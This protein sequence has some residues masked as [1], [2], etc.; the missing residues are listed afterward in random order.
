MS[1]LGPLFEGDFN[2]GPSTDVSQFG[3]GDLSVHRNVIINGTINS[4][5]SNSIGSLLLSG[6]ALI[7][8]DVHI[9]G[10]LFVLYDTTNLTITHIDTNNGAT[11]ITGGNGLQVSVGAASYIIS[12]GGNTTIQSTTQQLQ[13][14]GGL[15]GQNAVDINSTDS[16]G[17]IRILSGS[18]GLVNIV[19]GSSGISGFTSS[20]NLTLTAN[21]A[22]GS[23]TVNSSSGS[24]NLTL[25]LTGSTDSGISIQSSGINTTNTAITMNTTNTAGNIKISNVDG[26]GS[27]SVNILTG[28]GG[29]TVAT[30]TGGSISQSSRAASSSYIVDSDGANQNLNLR[31]TGNT[32]SGINIISSGINTTNNAISILTTNT[33]GSILIRQTTGSVAGVSVYTGSNGFICSTMTGGSIVMTSYGANSYYTNET[34]SDN[35]NL[36]ISVN[37]NTDSRVVISSTGKTSDAIK[38][39]TTNGTGGI[40][41]DSVGPIGI[42][43]TDT[44]NGVHI[45]TSTSV[46]IT[47]GTNTSV[48]TI[49]GDLYVRGN[50]SSVDLQ[51]VTIDD[52]I[53]TVNNAPY[54]TSD[55]GYAIKRYQP[56]NDSS[57]GDV[58]L[59]TADI[60]GIIQN[61]GN[62]T[63]T[64]TL[65]TGASN[66]DDYYVGWWIRIT[67]G[68][69]AGQVRKV[70]DYDG[71][72]KLLTIFGSSDQAGVLGSPQPVEGLDFNTILD[73]TSTYGL[74]PCHY[75]M[76]IWDESADEFALVCSS[77]NPSDPDNPVFE[78]NISHYSNLHINNLQSNAI[79]TNTIN[80]SAADITTNI[81]LVDNANTPVAITALPF[82]YGIYY[83][84]VKPLSNTLRTHA[85]FTIG[86]LNSVSANG[87]NN[88]IFSI[89][90][91][92]NEHVGIQWTAN[93]YPELYYKDSPGVG[94]TTTYKLKIISL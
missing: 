88:R 55:G 41:L 90:G 65:D 53:M 1:Y 11:T 4:T 43:T 85:M 25:S 81:T 7:D 23:F 68:T 62:T 76:N 67:G 80:D 16:L 66:T 31:L 14:Y 34:T 33:N 87:Q 51:V 44:I 6:G 39:T 94:G 40:L 63:T 70:K 58:V 64:T 77:N 18:S 82:N 8:K 15:N 20:G 75:V 42:Q 91:T 30:N 56:A 52:N 5:G 84:I 27:G 3:Y 47:L 36:Y 61:T 22:S 17:G 69:G 60:T 35:Q 49:L 26:L 32:D 92:Q 89:K 59:D 48:T 29:Y 45:G 9:K 50:T 19:G 57:L 86:R 79:Y 24:Q 74:Y 21:N 54:G 83:I 73:N 93:Q 28:S 46:P 71:T 38:L 72:S 10:K 2:I 13:L 37:G 78:P 12:T